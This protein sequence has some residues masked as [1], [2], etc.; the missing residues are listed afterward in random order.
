MGFLFYEN[1]GA[2]EVCVGAAAMSLEGF[3]FGADSAWQNTA[4]FVAATV[5]LAVALAL[6]SRDQTVRV[7]GGSVTALAWAESELFPSW[8]VSNAA[9]VFS[10]VAA[11][12][13]L[14]CVGDHLAAA[15]NWRTDKL[16]RRSA[17][18]A[19]ESMRSVVDGFGEAFAG[20]PLFDLEQDLDVRSLRDL[21]RMDGAVGVSSEARFAA[22]WGAA[23]GAT[24]SLM[25]RE[26]WVP[27]PVPL[28]LSH[29]LR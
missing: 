2:A 19:G 10:L 7:R 29:E 8:R 24:R 1:D 16:S 5:G 26:G 17:W 23:S 20:V 14:D 27:S 22:L 11:A 15:L 3:D 4:E 18:S 6:G 25:A 28:G 12:G 21:C 13:R 9:V